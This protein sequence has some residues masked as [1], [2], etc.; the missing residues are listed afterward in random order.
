M[1]L[2]KIKRS[3][4]SLLI[5]FFLLYII[6]SFVLRIGF[7]IASLQKAEISFLSL[8]NVFALGFLFDIGVGVFFVLPYSLYLLLFP[9]KY[10]NSLFNRAMTFFC[11]NVAV[12]ILLFSFFAEVTFW[13]EFESRFNFIAVDYLV[14]TYEVINN[15]NESYPLPLLITAMLIMTSLVFLLFYKRHYFTDNFKGSTPFLQRFFIFFGL[16]FISVIY[17]FFIDNSL[18]ENSENRYRNELSKSGIYSFFSAYKNNEINYEHF[19]KLIDNRV[20]FNIVRTD[21]QESNSDYLSNDFSILRNIKGADSYEKPNVIMIT[22][23][24]FS[25]DF[26][27]TFGNNQNLTPTLDSLANQSILFTNMYA[28]GTRTVRGM[29]ALSLAVPPT[30]GNSIVRRKENDN[31]STVGSIFSQKGYDTSFLYGG[32]GYFDNMNNYFGN[33]GY[34]IVDRKRN[35]FVG[36]DYQSPRIPIEDKEVTFE[37]AWGISDENLYDQ[38]IKQADQKFA[39]GKPFY[40]F[41]MNTSNHR[42]YTY[43]EG[44]ID[45]P[46]GSGR[47]GAVKYTDYAIGQFFKKIKN[48]SWYKNTIVIIVADHC[49]SSAGKN[50]IDVA[51]YH[52]PAMIVNLN[53]NEPFRIE[54][55]CSQ[56]DLYPTLFAL[57]GWTYQSNLYGKNVLGESYI[58][59]IFVSTYQKLGYME[60]NKLVILGPQQKTETYLYDKEKNKQNPEML[61]EQYVKK[62]IANYQSAYYLFKNE[63]LKQKRIKKGNI[64]TTR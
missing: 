5:N 58:P 30:P 13:Q 63:G 31:L 1:K 28:T 38:V 33:N 25:A 14:Y 50:D 39:A 64:T 23:E 17:A 46:S 48:K 59:R 10:N 21:L 40:D 35:S 53:D 7:S 12:L 8:L 52:I 9:Q 45:I 16:L 29:E 62:A 32:D 3:S 61:S 26:M 36:E 54:K 24:S 27:K 34:T 49:A 56:I 43:P 60:N 44:K 22:L 41:V 19:Y 15:I 55:M 57:L 37:N 51:K 20:A 18:A 42:P 4:Y 47:E 11:F 2:I 6:F